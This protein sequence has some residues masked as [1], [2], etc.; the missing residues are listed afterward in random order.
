[1]KTPTLPPGASSETAIA[2][3]V[4]NNSPEFLTVLQNWHKKSVPQTLDEYYASHGVDPDIVKGYEAAKRMQP[5]AVKQMAKVF[6]ERA[7]SDAAEIKPCLEV[8]QLVLV[9]HNNRP[10]HD[11]ASLIVKGL[12]KQISLYHEGGKHYAL[13]TLDDRTQN[14]QQAVAQLFVM[15]NPDVL[16]EEP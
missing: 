13:A 5:D 11:G 15:F 4:P 10:I 2:L 9:L 1:M 12:K 6:A 7:S 14:M 8:G 16:K 3:A